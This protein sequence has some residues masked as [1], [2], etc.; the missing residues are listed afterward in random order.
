[1]FSHLYF[2]WLLTENIIVVITFLIVIDERHNL[3]RVR[4]RTINHHKKKACPARVA[5][6]GRE[7]I[8]TVHEPK[9]IQTANLPWGHGR[10][11]MEDFHDPQAQ[12]H[13]GTCAIKVSMKID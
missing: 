6:T 8:E 2:T 11:A 7:N 12:I 4:V 13:E 1:V 9:P 10:R 3:T 5:E